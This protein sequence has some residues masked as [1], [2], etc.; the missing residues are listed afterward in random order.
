[1]ILTL[2]VFN[3]ITFISIL[4]YIPKEIYGL[5]TFHL[6]FFLT[7]FTYSLIN[8]NKKSLI[9]FQGQSVFSIILPIVLVFS[10]F[11]NAIFFP[12]DNSSG[13]AYLIYFIFILFFLTKVDYQLENSK[14]INLNIIIL[15]ILG[16]FN[17]IFNQLDFQAD[18][19]IYGWIN[20]NVVGF[21]VI[22]NCIFLL[23]EVKNKNLSKTYLWISLIL[24]FSWSVYSGTRI[25][26]IL[27]PILIITYSQ[28][29]T[30]NFI[31]FTFV[32]LILINLSSSFHYSEKFNKLAIIFNDLTT[33]N[34]DSFLVSEANRLRILAQGVLLSLDNFFFGVGP[35]VQ[36]IQSAFLNNNFLTYFEL[37]PHNTFVSVTME[38]GIFA[39]IVLIVFLEKISRNLRFSQKIVFVFFVAGTLFINEFFYNPLYWFTLIKLQSFFWRRNNFNNVNRRF[40]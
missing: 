2:S 7:C 15:C 40:S 5:P 26:M 24:M 11:I 12:F 37:K 34:L 29:K 9:G 6:V 3:L 4:F 19:N 17:A 13:L 10:Y 16:V 33:L 31:L 8:R 27:I 21:L 18:N 38:Y 25:V 22:T 1:M 32:A 35:G 36:N 28:K 23:E 39:L 20:N 14:K 30:I